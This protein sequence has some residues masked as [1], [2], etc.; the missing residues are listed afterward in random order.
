MLPVALRVYFENSVGRILE[1]PDGYAVVQY[2][3]GT[4]EIAYLQAFLRHV[5]QLLKLRGWYKILGDQRLMTPYT[6]EES[7]WITDYWL[8]YEN[9]AR[10]I[11]GAVMMATDA[12]AQLPDSYRLQDAQ[13]GAMTYRLFDNEA[14]ALDWLHQRL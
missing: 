12:W 1:H 2:H 8:S 3:A 6:E 9:Q 11:Y 14:A 13:A 7:Q 5:G 4:R 10:E